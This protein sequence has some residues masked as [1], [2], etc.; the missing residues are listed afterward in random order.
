MPAFGES[1]GE[2]QGATLM[3]FYNRPAGSGY[4]LVSQRLLP[5]DER[6]QRGAGPSAL[7]QDPFPPGGAPWMTDP[8]EILGVLRRCHSVRCRTD[9]SCLDGQ[10]ERVNDRLPEIEPAAA[11]RVR[12]RTLALSRWENEGGA[13]PASST[14]DAPRLGD[15]EADQLRVRVIALENLVIALLADATDDQRLLVRD[16]ADYISPRPGY[17]PHPLTLRA[18]EAMRS[19]LDR[20]DRFRPGTQG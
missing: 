7:A 19:L 2:P 1:V 18:A 16:M 20:A 5:L 15:A 4:A 8:H 11:Q 13:G 10:S 14:G 6:W 3:L 17:T 9:G 12:L